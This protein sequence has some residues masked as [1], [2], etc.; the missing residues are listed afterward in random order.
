M[1]LMT[2]LLL[3]QV[4]ALARNRIGYAVFRGVKVALS[5]I[6]RTLYVLWLQTT[7]FVFGVFTVMGAA[8]LV[9]LSRAHAWDHDPQRFWLTLVF[10]AVCLSF[11]LMSFW[12]A[13]RRSN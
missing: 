6:L 4:K 10:T 5:S 1:A 12:K 9:R 13:K 7:G 8:A 2:D 3:N 11:T